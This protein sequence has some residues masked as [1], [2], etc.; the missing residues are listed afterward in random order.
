MNI[1]YSVASTKEELSSLAKI[2]LDAQ[3]FQ[4][5]GLLKKHY[6]VIFEK[7]QRCDMYIVMQYFNGVPVG[8]ITCFKRAKHINIYINPNYRRIG[9]G[10]MLVEKLRQEMG[11]ENSLLI[12]V[13]GYEGWKDFFHANFIYENIMYFS[14]EEIRTIPIDKLVVT[15]NLKYK[16]QMLARLRRYRK[17]LKSI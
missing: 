14:I 16:R 2:C 3:L 13:E 8:A 10:S 17:S 6:E 5:G 1:T 12:G 15:V 7:K 4:P 9:L 11:L